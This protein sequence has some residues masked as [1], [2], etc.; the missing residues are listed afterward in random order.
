MHNKPSTCPNS[1]FHKW[2][3][4]NYIKNKY[5]N[6]YCLISK[7]NKTIYSKKSRKKSF[8]KMDPFNMD[9]NLLCKT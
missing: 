4:L 9:K 6:L 3:K 8:P 5:K 7:S 1:S 2:V